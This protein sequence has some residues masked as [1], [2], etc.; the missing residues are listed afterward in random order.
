MVDATTSLLGTQM[1][2]CGF[3]CFGVLN[4]L[5]RSIN[6]LRALARRQIDRGKGA[7]AGGIRRALHEATNEAFWV[8][9]GSLVRVVPWRYVRITALAGF[10]SH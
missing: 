4:P 3:C 8:R 9:V 2:H 6:W 5:R 1:T 7:S 10:T